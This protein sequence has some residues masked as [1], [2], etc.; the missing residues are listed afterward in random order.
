MRNAVWRLNGNGRGPSDP[1][2][3]I[4]VT[5]AFVFSGFQ[6]PKILQDRSQIR[7]PARDGGVPWLV[8]FL[9][10]DAANFK[11][12]ALVAWFGGRRGRLCL[13]VMVE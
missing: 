1:P 12:V 8:R 11:G 6:L 5:N 4:P 3:P 9:I 10:G 13:M 2:P 7:L